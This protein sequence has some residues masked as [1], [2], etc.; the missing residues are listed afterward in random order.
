M[1]LLDLLKKE[2]AEAGIRIACTQVVRAARGTLSTVFASN[3]RIHSF[4]NS[5][6]G[7]GMLT[8]VVGYG[9]GRSDHNLAQSIGHEC[10]VQGMTTAGNGVVEHFTTPKEKT[11]EENK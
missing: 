5:K 1:S 2:G 3:P 4:V 6:L 10:R 7:S 8:S 11:E 9:L